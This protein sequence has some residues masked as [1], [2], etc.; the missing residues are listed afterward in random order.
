MMAESSQY[1]D[2]SAADYPSAQGEETL[3]PFAPNNPE[4]PL[5]W[6]SV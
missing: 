5:N 2:A 6:P 1:A 4:C 3:V